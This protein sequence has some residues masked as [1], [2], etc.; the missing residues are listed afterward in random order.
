MPLSSPFSQHTQPLVGRTPVVEQLSQHLQRAM[1]GH[2]SLVLLSG[3]ADIGKTHLVTCLREEASANGALVLLGHSYDLSASPPYG[4]WRQI[5]SA[6]RSTCAAGSTWLPPAPLIPTLWPTISSRLMTP[7]QWN[8]W[9]APAS[10]RSRRTHR[11]TLSSAYH[12]RSS[13]RRRS[14]SSRRVSDER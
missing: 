7:A 5:L 14:T 2:G 10:T 1:S 3:E 4:P 6:G 8:G 11:T 13:S 9:R 12:A